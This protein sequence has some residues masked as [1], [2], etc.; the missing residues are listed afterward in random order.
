MSRSRVSRWASR[1]NRSD[2]ALWVL[3]WASAAE[4]IIVPIPIEL[5]LIPFMVTNRERLWRTAAMVT[6]GC[7]AASAAGYGIGYLFFDTVGR[8]AIQQFGWSTQMEE[9]RSLFNEYGFWAIVAVG[10]IPIPFQTAMLAAGAA[11]YSIL[12]FMLAAAIARG[13]R[14]FGLALLVHL[15]GDRAE[16][17]W[18]RHKTTASL[19]ATALT[20]AVAAAMIWL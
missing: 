18:K 9:F 11:G 15:V 16:A 14:Y 7:L 8:E 19:T 4:T 1:I 10:V 6:A 13:I 12:L 17:F 20:A 3:F 2:R 5:V